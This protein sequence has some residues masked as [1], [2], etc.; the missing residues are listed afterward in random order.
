MSSGPRQR[1]DL[2]GDR[3]ASRDL[4][5]SQFVGC[6]KVQPAFGLAAEVALQAQGRVS[7]HASLAQALNG[8]RQAR[9]F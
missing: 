1:L 8:L 6:L 2:F 7:G 3:F 9:R 5:H 4:G